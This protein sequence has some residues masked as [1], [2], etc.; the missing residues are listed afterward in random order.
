MAPAKRRPLHSASPSGSPGSSFRSSRLNFRPSPGMQEDRGGT[1]PTTSPSSIGLV[2]MTM[3]LHICK[4]SL[5]FDPRL[6]VAVYCG[7]I[8]VVSLV[9]D[10]APPP[11]TYFARSDNIFNRYFVKWGWGWL[12]TVMIPWVLLTGYTTACGKRSIVV[13]HLM[14]IVLA[15]FFWFFWTKLF[16]HVETTYGRCLGTRESE[17]QKKTNCLRAGKFWSGFDISGHTFILIYSSL[18][19]AE[20]GTALLGWE[21]INDM[22]VKEEHSRSVQER[23]ASPLK[24]LTDCELDFLKITHKGLSPYVRGLF[25]GMTLQQVLWDVMVVSTMLY[26][27]T[28]IEKFVGGVIAVLTWFVTYR[29]WF[30]L[31]EGGLLLPGDGIFK[32]NETRKPVGATRS[33]RNTL[34]GVGPSFMGMPLRTGQREEGRTGNGVTSR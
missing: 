27:H 3:L 14:R 23:S 29:W 7:A 10:L 28:M 34:N 20:E 21:G 25:V 17:L 5:L 31:N 16:L 8:F 12:L 24:E 19:L 4:K 30:T 2:L 6:K 15:T 33:R 13:R 26:Y 9:A 32:Y 22:V 18:I 1:K 11:K